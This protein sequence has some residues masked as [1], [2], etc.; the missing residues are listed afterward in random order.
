MAKE[1]NIKWRKI[2]E[3]K[4]KNTIKNYNAKIDRLAKKQDTLKRPLPDKIKYSDVK[5]RIGTRKEFNKTIDKLKT[6]TQKGGETPKSIR[7]TDKQEADLQRSVKKFNA[8][9]DKLAKKDPHNKTA[10]P[11]KASVKKIRELVFNR[12][13][14]TRE[15]KTLEAFSKT[16]A[17]EL[18]DIPGTYTNT[19]ITR[20]QKE[21]MEKYEAIVNA[22]REKRF[23]EIKE[24][25]VTSFGEKTGYTIG[26]FYDVDNPA[27]MNRV[28]DVSLRPQKA[29]TDSMDRTG[30]NKRFAYMRKEAASGYYDERDEILRTNYIENGIKLNY[31]AEDVADVID[32]MYSMDF[33][34]FY[35]IFKSEDSNWED[36]YRKSDDSLYESYVEKL[37]STWLPKK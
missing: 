7:W 33:K 31:R 3:Q 30:V 21:Q 9:I 6:F 15:L 26:E 1:Y 35:E 8:K 4:L 34:E 16:G 20:W 29:F 14:L 19:K 25:Q 18:V 17:E 11:E 23:N 13:D 12:Q 22:K 27:R 10:L 24:Y 37:R 32:A 5:D 36:A 28:D 2:D